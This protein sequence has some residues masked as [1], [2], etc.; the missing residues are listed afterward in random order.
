MLFDLRGRGRRNTVKVIYLLLAILM[1]G[2]L[3]LFGIGGNTSGGLVDAITGNGG[4]A[5]SGAKAY[6]ENRDEARAAIQAD[7]GNDEAWLDLITSYSAL[8]RSTDDYDSTNRTY[9]AEGKDYLRQS[10]KAYN[11]YEATKPDDRNVRGQAASLALNAYAALGETQ[12]AVDAAEVYA[13]VKNTPQAYAVF[14][15]YAYREGQERKGELAGQKA[16]SLSD[17]TLRPQIK[18]SLDQSKQAAA[19]AATQDALP[20]ATPSATPTK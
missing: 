16:L 8:A 12:G 18:A 1:G 6:R 7:R 5:N 2:G 17:K 10:V 14:A 11:D 3:V 20:S 13:E 4:N 15:D 9:D 19:Q